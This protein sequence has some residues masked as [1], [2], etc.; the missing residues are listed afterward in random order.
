MNAIVEFSGDRIDALPAL[1]RLIWL[2][3]GQA[4]EEAHAGHA[5]TSVP[6]L[7]LPAAA[8]RDEEDPAADRRVKAAPRRRPRQR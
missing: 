4:V 5:V 3:A 7:Q 8:A 1:R 6:E 2:L